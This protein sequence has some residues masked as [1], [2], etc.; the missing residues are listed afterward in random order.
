MHIN[1]STFVDR[2]KEED[3][4]HAYYRTLPTFTVC[5][6]VFRQVIIALS[7]SYLETLFRF[8]RLV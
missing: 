5:A 6:H 8:A 4:C 2:E 7:I 3:K 1:T